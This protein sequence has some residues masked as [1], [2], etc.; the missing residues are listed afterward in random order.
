VPVL[1][2]LVRDLR[3]GDQDDDRA[4]GDD[5]ERQRLLEQVR[6]ALALPG[7]AR[8]EVADEGAGEPRRDRGP[9]GRDLEDPVAGQQ[10]QLTG[11]GG[12]Q[13]GQYE[14]AE[15]LTELRSDEGAQLGG[16]RP[17][18]GHCFPSFWEP[19]G[20]E[21]HQP[22][23]HCAS[24]GHVYSTGTRRS[25]RL[26]RGMCRQARSGDAAPGL[27]GACHSVP[28]DCELN[29]RCWPRPR[30][31]TASRPDGPAATA[32]PLR[33]REIPACHN[34]CAW[35]SGLDLANPRAAPGDSAAAWRAGR[36]PPTAS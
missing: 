31:N 6:A 33:T 29:H 5:P 36:L 35:P 24:V 17:N 14:P 22:L 28:P 4:D 26:G 34:T 12:N 10:G 27:R 3:R 23:G 20:Q 1:G 19:A 25:P 2:S 16:D 15:P 9:A 11:A 30:Q 8:H 7:P 21:G 13:G 18:Q 32:G